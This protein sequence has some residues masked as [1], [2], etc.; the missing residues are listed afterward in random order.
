M[1]FSDNFR[2]PDVP[3]EG[4][5]TGN[6]MAL[7][8]LVRW[9]ILPGI[10][11]FIYQLFS[12]V[13]LRWRVVTPNNWKRYVT[14]AVATGEPID[15]SPLNAKAGAVRRRLIL[16]SRNPSYYSTLA[17]PKKDRFID[18]AKEDRA[19]AKEFINQILPKTAYDASRKII[20]GF[21]HPFCNAGGGGERVLWQGV[22]TTLEVDGNNICLI[23]TGDLVTGDEVLDNVARNFGISFTDEERTK[24]VFIHL[25]KR[26]YVEAQYWPRLTL[27]GQA[28]GS[29]LLTLEALQKVVPDV[30]VDTM[31]YPF[32]NPLVRVGVKIPIITYTHYPII[33]TDMLNKIK[34]NSIKT[35]AKKIYW[36][37]FMLAYK[38]VGHCVDIAFVNSTWTSNHMKKIWASV[39]VIKTVYPPIGIEKTITVDSVS[40][41]DKIILYIAQFRPEKRHQLLINEFS[42]FFQLNKSYKLVMIG[43]I[44]SKDDEDRVDFL[45]DLAYKK[46][47]IPEE[48]LVIIKDASYSVIQDYLSKAEIGVNAMWNEHFGIAIV[49]YMFNGLIPLAHASSGPYLDICVPWSLEKG[50]QLCVNSSKPVSD[51]SNRTG[52]LFISEEDPDIEARTEPFPSLHEALL[53]ISKLSQ[54]QKLEILKRGAS[55]VNGKFQDNVFN[56]NWKKAIADAIKLEQVYRVSKRDGEVEQIF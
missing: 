1:D 13:Y 30:W 41:R 47:G 42:K 51:D 6:K 7:F 11:L 48:N 26:K 16:G 36:W 25:Y 32:S 29:I 33:S 23:Y 8:R 27:A 40:P 34:I 24:V 46:K 28:F 31:G 38:F 21:F 22:K 56:Q 37:G 9:F 5:S 20:F 49:E 2:F 50:E 44:R 43:S 3:V 18:I 12:R 14:K 45:K 52:Y 55:V 54:E 10:V 19:N 15:T 39:S 53:D 17:D 35:L 4:T